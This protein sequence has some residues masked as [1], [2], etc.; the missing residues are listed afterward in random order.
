MALTEEQLLAQLEAETVPCADLLEQLD[1][2]CADGKEVRAVEWGEL[3]KDTLI[4]RKLLDEAV[5]AYEW[6]ALKQGTSPAIAQKELLHILATSRKEQKFIEPAFEKASSTEEA[7]LRLKHLRSMK[8]GMLCY[9]KT[10]GFGIVNRV[11]PFY[12]KVEVSFEKKGDH[13]LAFSYAADALDVLTDDHLMAVRHNNPDEF[14]RLMKENPA[15]IIRMTLRSYGPLSLNLIQ[16]HFM[17]DLI[18]TEADWKKFWDAA[19]KDLKNDPLIEIPSKRTDPL[20]LR[21]KAKAYD[22]IWFEKFKAERDMPAVFQGLEEIQAQKFQTLE[23]YMKEAIANRLAFAV[24]GG[25]LNQPGWIAQALVYAEQLGVEP[26]SVDCTAELTKLA[27]RDDLPALLEELP[28]RFMQAFISRLFTASETARSFLLRRLPEFG[29]TALNE[30]I[31]ALIRNGAE[32]ELTGQIRDTV[33]RRACSP[34]LLLWILRNEER[35]AGWQ[36]TDK[37]DLAFQTI[38][39]IEQEHCGAALRAQNQLREQIE[40][41]DSLK[42][43]LAAMSDSQRRDFMRR[44][45]DSP[46][47]SKLDRQSLQ[48]K[49]IK[50]CPDLHEIVLKKT[51]AAP[52]EKNPRITSPRS[53][54]AKKDQFEHILK[55]EIPEN[56]KEIELARSYGDLRENSE[57]KFAK[58]KQ[59]LLSLQAEELQKALDEVKPTDF[60]GFPCDVVGIATGVEL[61]YADGNRENYYILGEWDQ[62][63][64]LHIISSQAGMAKA[65]AGTKAGS[66]VRVPTSSG[67]DVEVE[68]T[69]VTALPEHIRAWING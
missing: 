68:V 47:W 31:E 42:S 49:T 13:E 53:Y 11:D 9:N 4:D 27:G 45:S 35:A 38:E 41:N 66:R 60:T 24:K 37:A 17:P 1:A 40:D 14:V 18:A 59:R 61:V 12:Q 2:L 21:R 46:A 67:I 29:T 33:R 26:E 69:A 65:L 30:T 63:E 39:L 16:D 58:E 32:T 28:S 50:I 64:T 8:K 62:D 3:L 10:W 56:S 19:R 22:Q 23:S 54:Q 5:A 36:L 48:A 7:F 52:K 43:I 15:E 57:F 51:N 6:L 44:I 55:K 25:S 34:A 20:R